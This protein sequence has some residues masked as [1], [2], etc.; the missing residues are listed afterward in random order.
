VKYGQLKDKCVFYTRGLQRD[1]PIQLSKKATQVACR[2]SKY[3]IWHLWTNKIDEGAD[4]K[5]RINHYGPYLDG[6]RL[7][8]LTTTEVDDPPPGQLKRRPYVIEYFENMSRALAQMCTGT[9]YLYTTE[10]TNLEIFY[11]WF[12]LDPGGRPLWPN[13]WATTESTELLTRIKRDI[14]DLI[15]ID[16]KSNANT[17]PAYRIE[18]DSWKNL[19]DGHLRRDQVGNYSDGSLPPGVVPYDLSAELWGPKTEEETA[20]LARRAVD[21]CLPFEPEEPDGINFFA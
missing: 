17:P 20:S 21:F 2:H 12:E 3:S 10:P 7:R 14:G 18:W 15:T 1:G 6:N 19:G 9:I 4:P 8:P 5:N 13:I 16:A 11:S